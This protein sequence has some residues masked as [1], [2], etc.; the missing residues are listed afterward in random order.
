MNRDVVCLCANCCGGGYVCVCGGVFEKE[1][2]IKSRR[3]GEG[4][5][6]LGE[7]GRGWYVLWLCWCVV[8]AVVSKGK[9]KMRK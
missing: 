8:G 7:E 2:M 3:E 5:G 1:K 6:K 4:I 9:R